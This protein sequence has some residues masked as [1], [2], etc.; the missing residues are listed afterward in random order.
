MTMTLYPFAGISLNT[1]TVRRSRIRDGREADLARQMLRLGTPAHLVAA[2]FGVHPWEVH[3]IAGTN[4]RR[5][6][7]RH[8][9]GGRGD[10]RQMPLPL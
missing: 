2:R 6:K 3:R 4:Q 7:G 8:L 1:I 5:P 9:R 10:A